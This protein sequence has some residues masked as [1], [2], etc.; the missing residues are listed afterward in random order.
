MNQKLAILV[1][2]LAIPAHG[3]VLWSIGADDQ[4]QDGNG[5]GTL[6]DAAT[7]NGVG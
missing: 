1:G 6:G 4:A 5:D 7:L 2:L 3:A